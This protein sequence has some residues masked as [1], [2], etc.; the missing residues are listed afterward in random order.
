VS[1]ARSYPLEITMTRPLIIAITALLLSGVLHAQESKS[2]R[3]E[4]VKELRSDMR[5]WF[6]SDVLPT[7]SRWHAEYDAS[8]SREDLAILT[9]LRADAKRLRADVRRDLKSLRADFE[10]GGRAELRN[11]MKDLREK[12]QDSYKQLLEQLKPIAKRSR[13]KLREIF[14]SN[15]ET[16]EKWR[17]DAKRIIVDWKEDHDDLDLNRGNSQFPLLGGNPR[18][19]AI[20]FILWDGTMPEE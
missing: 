6:A 11:R 8:L 4:A 19:S 5:S 3:Q 18:R 17:A 16:I 20:R 2:K 9:R 15:E 12:Y 7:M 14:D 10:R 1:T 13:T